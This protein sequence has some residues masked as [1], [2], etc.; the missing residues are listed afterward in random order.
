M[1][2]ASAS[3]ETAPAP[4]DDSGWNKLKQLV[5]DGVSAEKSKRSYGAVLDHF[6]GWYFAQ[7]RAV[8]SKA[9]VQ[10]YRTALDRFGYAPST[11]A[12]SL[13]V[14]RK[15]AAEAADNGLLDPQI[16]AGVCRIRSPKRLGRRVGN[17]L[18]EAQA[19]ALIHAPESS[20]L[21]GVRDRA[22]LAV[23][24]G[25]GLRRS[26]IASLTVEHLQLRE[27]RWIIAD[28]VGK[29]RRTRTVPI[30]SWVKKWLDSWLN[31][32]QIT[33]GRV[34]RSV[35]KAD[36][37]SGPS[38]TDQAM[39]DVV[40]TWSC[41]QG[42]PIAPHDLRRTFAKLAH[43][44]GARVEQIQYSLGHGSLTTTERYLGLEQDLVDAPGDRIHLGSDQK[45]VD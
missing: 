44:G 6:Y 33:T 29:N 28:L 13:S 24:V 38:M 27:G 22:I 1:P 30:P 3:S 19:D 8:F 31:Q 20:T 37:L 21:K 39:Y 34:F 43:A 12:L 2:A 5:L 42:V 11:I 25:C 41:R 45:I 40:K 17:W 32:A 10:E 7:P 4:I 15:L 23:G 9:V 36:E 35:T 14:L 18:T 26:E 16:A